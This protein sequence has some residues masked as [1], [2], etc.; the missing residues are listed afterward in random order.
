MG[1]SSI[2]SDENIF[3]VCYFIS[4]LGPK[5]WA[6][7]CSVNGMGEQN[8]GNTHSGN[9]LNVWSRCENKYNILIKV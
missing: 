7:K 2:G 6:R 8:N 3:G 4:E 9:N 5:N 1:Y